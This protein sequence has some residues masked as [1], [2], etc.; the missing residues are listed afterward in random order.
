MSIE[1]KKTRQPD[2]YPFHRVLYAWSEATVSEEIERFRHRN[3]T[4]GLN[5]PPE[6]IHHHRHTDELGG[7]RIKCEGHEHTIVQRGTA[8]AAS[9]GGANL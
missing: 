1:I 9:G 7:A 4:L 5:D 2:L 8:P 3:D 6:L